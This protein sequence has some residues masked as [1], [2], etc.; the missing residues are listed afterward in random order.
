V[1]IAVAFACLA[2]SSAVAVAAD[3]VIAAAGDIACD[4]ASTY[5]NG[6][7]GDATHCRQRYTSDLL[8][9]R[10]LTATL[11]MGDTQYEDGVLSKFQGS[12]DPTWGRVKAIT[13]PAIGNH[14]YETAGAGYFDY[15]DGVGGSTGPAGDRGKGYYSFDVPLPSGSRWHL[16]ALNSE[17]A[18]ANAADEGVAGACAA[19]SAQEQWLRSDLAAHPGACTLAF[20]HHPLFS[21]GGIGNHPAMQT[22][23]QDLYTAGADVV[24]N[25][26]DHNY[27]RFGPQDPS[28][29][30]DPTYGL[31]ELV[32]GTGGKSL[33]AMGTVKANSEVRQNDTYGV[34]ELTLHDSGYDWRFTPESGRTFTDA[35]SGACHGAPPPGVFTGP[36][37]SVNAT[38]A[39]LNATVNPRYQPTTYHFDYGPSTAYGAS[40]PDQSLTGDA[41]TH[42]VTADL[43]GLTAGATYHYRVVATNGAGRSLGA[44]ATFTAGPASRYAS[45][46]LGTSGLA[47]YWR[48]GE[49]GGTSAY[50]ERAANLGSYTGG[51]ALGQA[52]ALGGDPNTAAGFNGTSSEMTAGGPR[53]SSSG[54][55]EGWFLWQGGVALVRDHTSTSSSGWILAYDSGGSLNYRVAGKTFATGRSAASVRNGWH[56]FAVTKNAGNVAFYLDGQLVASGTGAP[57]TAAAMPWHVMRNGTYAG[58]SQG[59]ADELAIYTAAL[60]ASTIKAHYDAGRSASTAA[61]AARGRRRVTRRGSGSL[62]AMASEGEYPWGIYTTPRAGGSIRRLANV[63]SEVPQAAAWSPGGH[64]VAFTRPSCDECD[65]RLWLMTPS[66]AGQRP[67][68]TRVAG[69]SGPSWSSDGRAVAVTGLDGAVR[70]IDLRTG[71][72]RRV[73]SARRPSQNGDWSPVARRIV[74]ARRVS[75]TNWDLYT[76]DADGGHARRLTRGT[77]Q[78]LSPAWSPDGRHVAFQREDANGIWQIFI[79]DATGGHERQVTKGT[80]SSEQPS[81]SPNGSALAFVRVTVRGSRIVVARLSGPLRRAQP[82]PVTPPRLEAAFPAWSPDGRTILFSAKRAAALG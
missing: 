19:G 66:G 17:C 46:I 44:D 26:H 65:P 12:Y 23:W 43:T 39:R 3:P 22:I 74:T 56:H 33:L 30:T 25:G 76:V 69:I 13:R 49:A 79:V 9:G 71:A 54:T 28:G 72:A 24:L 32:V 81:W 15:F 67:V 29:A 16:I 75:A 8:I 2:W 10:G 35:G 20:W 14:E 1:A 4:P 62:P 37:G 34:L 73:T 64:R 58:Y 11:A 42:Q 57:N 27:E 80:A 40:T 45:A 6:G 50:D 52:G 82:A 53:L 61:P 51:V 38:S 68:A 60:P 70:T 41:L 78:E 5:F 77:G 36:A 48:L 31:R 7:V 59:F 21:S 18:A 63:G 55:I 47:S